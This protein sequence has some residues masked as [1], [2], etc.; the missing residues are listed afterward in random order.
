MDDFNLSSLHESKNEWC[1]RLLVILTPQII[2][3]FKS[4]FDEANQLCIKNNENNKYLMTFQNFISRIP[5]WSSAIIE[6]EKNRIIEKTNCNYLEDLITCV[7]VIQLKLLSVARAGQKQKKIDINIPHF[8]NFIHNVYINCARKIYTNVYLFEKHIDNPL[9]VQKNMRELEMLIQDAILNTVRDGVP[10]EAILNAYMDESIEEDIEEDVKEEIIHENI[11]S[12][13]GGEVTIIGEE[14]KDNKSDDI[15]SSETLKTEEL[16]KQLE[17]NSIIT[18]DDNIFPELVSPLESKDSSTS[19]SFNDID[20]VKDENNIET[21]ITASK[22]IERL[23]KISEQRNIERQALEENEE[24][25]K[26]KIKIFGDL[27]ASNDLSIQTLD[28][29][30]KLSPDPLLN[31]IEVLV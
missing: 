25:D 23:E 18:K 6:N 24:E 1:S 29:S 10:I 26:D 7:H 22:D 4:I 11:D 8:D 19:L 21:A 27:D 12:Q 9:L 20:M 17:S 13:N 2:V 15:N 3:G 14:E 30:I 5:K 16:P 31:D 28:N